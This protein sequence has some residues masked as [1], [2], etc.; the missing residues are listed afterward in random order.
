MVSAPKLLFPI[1]EHERLQSLYHYDILH[2]L[3]EELFDELVV[4]AAT[5]F[6]VP[7]AY[8]SLV[9][10]EQVHYKATFGF[11]QV[12]PAQPRAE[13]LCAQVVRQGQ[14]V[15]YHDLATAPQTALDAQA[16]QNAL[17]HEARFYAGA[18]LRMPEQHSIGALCLVDQTQRE[19]S[20]GEQEL[21]EVLANL[22]SQAIVVRCHCQATPGLGAACWH[23]IQL[24]AREE[25]YAL[26]A[27]VRYLAARYGTSTPVPEEILYPVC[28]RLIDLQ[29]ILHDH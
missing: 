21:L 1:D 7:I 22:V 3:R 15:V 20:A 19:F 27:L 4:L 9:A 2:S 23:S 24:Q 5:L 29:A 17:A 6:R 11:P 10:A 14:V 25:V 18:P 8:I 13:L 16:I 28:R 12:L 26:S